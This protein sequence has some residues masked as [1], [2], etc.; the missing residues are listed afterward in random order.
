M[1]WGIGFLV[2]ADG[3]LLVLLAAGALAMAY[4]FDRFD[5]R[6]GW[7][8]A[9]LGVTLPHAAYQA[10][11]PSRRYSDL[12]SVPSPAKL[13]VLLAV[14]AVGAIVVRRFVVPP[15]A[16]WWVGRQSSTRTWLLRGVGGLA[17]LGM[18]VF[19]LVCAYRDEVTMGAWGERPIRLYDEINLERLSWFITG[20]GFVL[21]LCGMAV[22]AWALPQRL[23]PW[24]L[25]V[26]ALSLLP[27]YLWEARVS[28]RLMWWGR[29]YVPTVLP[30][31]VVLV[32]V[33]L[34]AL[35]VR[36][37]R[38][39]WVGWI[40]GGVLL[41]YLLQFYVRQSWPLRDH[42]EMGGIAAFAA[43]VS[44]TTPAEGGKDPVLIWDYPDENDVFHD[45]SRNL[46]ATVWLLGDRPAAVL[47]E[48]LTEDVLDRYRGD[49]ADRTLYFV[50]RRAVVPDG[51]DPAGLVSAG[52][53]KTTTPVWEETYE[54]RP[55]EA[56]SFPTELYLWRVLPAD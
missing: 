48:P 53:L 17:V 42:R 5:W 35:L 45:P 54:E 12:N 39:A 32:A 33:A 10:W 29:R 21:L 43:T 51:V 37:G 19:L 3:I 13:G 15:L 8:A 44:A 30:V 47:R 2:R 38:H 20:T 40:V 36:R 56:K 4:A 31:I 49:F 9:G 14:L 11:G 55:D 7:F 52:Q 1:L 18:A 26:P 23:A 46:A 25:V 24:L 22:L 34:G 50:S 28:T 6:A 27:I 41:A 16:R